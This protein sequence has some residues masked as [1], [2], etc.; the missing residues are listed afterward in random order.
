MA[1]HWNNDEKDFVAKD[2]KRPAYHIVSAC[3]ILV[4]QVGK[5]SYVTIGAP[6]VQQI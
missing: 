2:G 5:P 1:P 4:S 3:A 6:V